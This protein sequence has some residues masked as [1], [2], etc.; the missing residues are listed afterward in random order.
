MRKS[1]GLNVLSCLEYLFNLLTY[2][3]LMPFILI[4]LVFGWL[5]GD[6]LL[7]VSVLK[8]AFGCG[9]KPHQSLTVTE[10]DLR[11]GSKEKS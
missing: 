10:I 5:T 8:L 9:R 1:A 7:H 11:E 4:Q 2:V 6:M 3:F